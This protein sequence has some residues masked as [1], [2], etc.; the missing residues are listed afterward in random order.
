MQGDFE[1]VGQS[2]CRYIPLPL[3]V[4][5]NKKTLDY[6]KELSWH[7]H[8]TAVMLKEAWGDGEVGEGGWEYVV[9]FVS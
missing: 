2:K 9:M 6:Y 4:F 3:H 1:I 7:F 8:V 5:L